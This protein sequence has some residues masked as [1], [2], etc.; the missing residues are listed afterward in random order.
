MKYRIFDKKR[1]RKDSKDYPYRYRCKICGVIYGSD[2][3]EFDNHTCPA[4]I[5]KKRKRSIERKKIKK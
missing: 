2:F 3:R 1:M 5:D 4:C